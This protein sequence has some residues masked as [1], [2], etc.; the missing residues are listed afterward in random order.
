MSDSPRATLLTPALWA[1]VSAQFD[2]LIELPTDERTRRLQVLGESSPAVA[3]AVDRLL[4]ADA[5]D[6]EL[7]MPDAALLQAALAPPQQQPGDAIG[8]YRLLR[9]LGQGGMSGVWQAEQ[10]GGPRRL[11]ALKLPFA[12]AETPSAAAQRFERERDLLAALEHPGIARLYDAGVD[13]SGQ[14]YLAMECVLGQPLNAHVHG[15]PLR[16]R[17]Q[18][19]LQVL[20]AVAH[21]H[22]RLIVHGDLKPA[23]ILVNQEGQV[24]LLDFG[25]ARLLDIDEGQAGPARA[26]LLP[27]AHTPRYSPPEQRAGQALT[28][29][30]DVYALGQVL[31]DVLRAGRPDA[32]PEPALQA[33]IEQASA[34]DPAQ[35]YG[36]VEALAAELQRWLEHW[37]VQAM[38]QRWAYRWR[39]W[40]RRHRAAAPLAGLGVAALLLG[41]SLALWQAHEA[42]VQARRAQLANRYLLD[43]LR[44]LDPRQAEAARP[45]LLMRALMQQKLAQIEALLPSDPELADELLKVSAT[46]YDYLGEAERSRALGQLRRT[47]ALAR[48]GGSDP[49]AQ[50]A[51]MA[52]V[53]P[54]LAL[55][56]GPAAERLLKALDAELPERG[57]L[58]AEWWLAEAD[59]LGLGT[60][61][62]QARAPAQYRAL[63]QALRRY[64]A[65]AP[66]DSGRVATLLGLA[67][68][69]A[70]EGRSQQALQTLAQAEAL[71]R[72]AEPY[73]ALDHVRLL[74]QQAR[75][76]QGLG[77]A[78]PALQSALQ[79]LQHL[80]ASLGAEARLARQPLR[81]LA[82][83]AARLCA[84]QVQRPSGLALERALQGLQAPGTSRGC[85]PTP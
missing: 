54:T 63:Q 81:E 2:L 3:R 61:E 68:L 41:L 15:L 30:A 32:A 28:V 47:Q 75:L 62:P 20:A 49:R 38:P 77:Q 84:A 12:L 24:K 5:L 73:V 66:S 18:L 9:L 36:S 22:G 69:E 16:Q 35:R 10:Q 11:V 76:Q 50:A 31:L 1:E 57:M 34:A 83:L 42:G 27:A 25:I 67:R 45:E 26:A 79:A 80:Q 19:F 40:L 17:V 64:E 72:H 7:R 44:T 85:A 56:D 23:N 8:P 37:P 52:L 46:V 29:G 51:G 82:E 60:A 39:C 58:R 48:W 33:V 6:T 74:V 21:A 55:Q 53:W 4:R 14:T 43:L 71:L 13:A 59:R 65:D 70:G 78:E